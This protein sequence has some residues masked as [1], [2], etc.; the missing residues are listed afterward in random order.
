MIGI[1]GK[2][3]VGGALHSSFKLR[4]IDI[5]VYD[6]YKNIGSMPDLLDTSIIFLCLPTPYVE[7][8]GFDKHSLYECCKFLTEH[9]YKGLVVIKSTVEPGTTNALADKYNL[10]II[11]NPEFMTTRTAIEDFENQKHIVLGASSKIENIYESDIYIFYKKHYPSANISICSSSESESVKLF[12]N[13]FYAI[14]VQ[15]FN[16]FYMLCKNQNLDY[17]NIKDIMLKNNWINKMHTDVPGPDGKLSYGGACFPKDTN[18]LANF[19]KEC[20]VSH[21]ILE[22]CISERNKFREE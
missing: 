14:K 11:H 21:E 10:K 15:V 6:K 5:V 20:D 1:V 3:I 22:A 2:G 18:A 16:E 9:S 13:N 12:L 17:N 8:I 4:G 19:M 7:N